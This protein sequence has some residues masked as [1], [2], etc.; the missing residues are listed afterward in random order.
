MSDI[1]AT[2]VVSKQM[3]RFRHKKKNKDD[4]TFSL[5]DLFRLPVTLIF[6]N[7]RKIIQ[8]NRK[9]KKIARRLFQTTTISY[10]SANYKHVRLEQLRKPQVAC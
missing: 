9:L 2:I 4:R 10:P 7:Q 6:H 3:A 1:K 5:L 8:I